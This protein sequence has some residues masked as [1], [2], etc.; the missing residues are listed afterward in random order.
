MTA[1]S[2]SA[3]STTTTGTGGTNYA[4]SDATC[5]GGLIINCYAYDGS[6]PHCDNGGAD[7]C[8]RNATCYNKHVQ[9]TC[10]GGAF[11]SSNCSAT[12]T[13]NYFQCD[14]STED[15]DGCEIN[16][17]ASCGSSTGTVVLNQCYSASAGN[18]TSSTRLDCDNDDTDSNTATCNGANGCEILIGGS[19]S[20]GSLSG[21]YGSSC[22]A[23]AGVC[24]V[25][26]S[27]FE[28]G[29]FIEYQTN[30]SQGGMLWF[31]DWNGDSYLIN[32]SNVNNK[33][34]A[35]NSSGCIKYMDNTWQC[36]ASSGTGMN[37]TNLALTNQTNIFTQNQTFQG[38]ITADW[39]FLQLTWSWL[40]NIPNVIYGLWTGNNPNNLLISNGTAIGYNETIL[41]QSIINVGLTGGFNSTY[42]STYNTWA[43]NQ[44]DGSY[45]ITYHNYVVANM[46]NSTTWWAT[47]SGWV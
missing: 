13:T 47:I 42:N 1:L 32:I 6:V 2:P 11:I 33:T 44:S 19:C 45:N 43:Y 12:C 26:K 15:A 25:S 5:D 10:K 22:S 21:T 37:Y 39:G 18:C 3:S 17:G 35:V 4:C 8:D 31:K 27:Y 40:R 23:G 38:N 16:A 36:T 46:S 7:L 20:I 9:T 41:N 14:G 30:T 29:T 28:T 24:V 34:W